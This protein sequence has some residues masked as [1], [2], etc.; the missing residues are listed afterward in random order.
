MYYNLED[1]MLY[2]SWSIG[3]K[4][5]DAPRRVRQSVCVEEGGREIGAE[6]DMWD[7]YAAHLY[8]AENMGEPIAAARMVPDG[9]TIR[10]DRLAVMPE[11]RSGIY[12]DLALRI[13]LDRAQAMPQREIVAMLSEEFSALLARFGF[14]AGKKAGEMRASRNAILWTSECKDSEKK[15]SP[16]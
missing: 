2:S 1:A 12:A 16:R 7:S 9:D 13:M 10:I 14:R 5:F 15:H 6:F 3:L 4:D 11:Y 8:I